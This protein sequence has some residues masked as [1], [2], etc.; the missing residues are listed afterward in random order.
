MPDEA[1]MGRH[2]DWLVEQYKAFTG[3]VHVDAEGLKRFLFNNMEIMQKYKQSGRIKSDIQ[4]LECNEKRA[5]SM[6]DW[7]NY[8]E[9]K[10]KHRFIKGTHWE[11]L[12]PANLPLLEKAVRG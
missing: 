2:L 5:A 9:G 8:T 12:F 6:K 4:A 3:D 1:S 10:L 11:A 7:A